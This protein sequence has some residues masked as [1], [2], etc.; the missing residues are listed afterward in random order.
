MRRKKAK[1]LDYTWDSAYKFSLSVDTHNDTIDAICDWLSCG[2]KQGRDY[3][4]EAI[5]GY[6]YPR[7]QWAYKTQR[8]YNFYI[9]D[10]RVLTELCLRWTLE[11]VYTPFEYF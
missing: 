11:K 1:E 10:P 6:K 3:E 9:M 2:R 5:W 7:K 8:Y 4:V